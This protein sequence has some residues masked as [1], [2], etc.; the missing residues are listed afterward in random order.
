MGARVL[1]S[2]VLPEDAKGEGH[3]FP[4]DVAG[5]R[6]FGEMPDSRLILEKGDNF[7]PPYKSRERLSFLNEH[8]EYKGPKGTATPRVSFVREAVN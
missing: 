8:L 2:R 1:L 3:W 5:K 4:C 6:A 7:R